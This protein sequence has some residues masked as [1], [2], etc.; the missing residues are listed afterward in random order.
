MTEATAT[1]ATYKLPPNVVSKVDLAHLISDAERIDN[2]LTTSAVHTR[3]NTAIEAELSTSERL[4]AF[5]QVNDLQF[6]NNSSDRMD[7]IRGL[8]RLKDS[9]PV[10]HMTFAVEADYESLG[11]LVAWLRS[12][13]HPQAIIAT[14]LQPALIAGVYLRT[15]NSVHDL[16]LR[17][18]IKGG[19]DVLIKELVEATRG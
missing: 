3:T 19:R 6:S 12:N 1:H 4:T 8:R 7:I 5:L 16:S 17:G 14:G 18:K 10:V 11:Q 2:E 13:V 15:S 9:A